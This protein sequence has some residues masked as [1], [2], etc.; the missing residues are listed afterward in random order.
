MGGLYLLGSL[1]ECDDS[2]LWFLSRIRNIVTNSETR[3]KLVIVTTKGTEK[4]ELIADALSKFP[5]E[6]VTR[7]DYAVPCPSPV[8]SAFEASMLLQEDVRYATNGLKDDVTGLILSCSHDERLC[9]LVIECLKSAPN[10]TKLLCQLLRLSQSGKLNPEV[11]FETIPG[12]IPSE[13]LRW[14]RKLLSWV[15]LSFRPLR[16]FEFLRISDICL[17]I[18]DKGH[19]T[20]HT[21]R[22]DDTQSLSSVLRYFAGMLVV[23]HGEIHFGHP[24][25]RAWF[26][27]Q[28]EP[29]AR[30]EKKLTH[31]E[32]V[33]TC[34]HHLQD[35]SSPTEIWA[36]QFPYAIQFW[37]RHHNKAGSVDGVLE[38]LF[39]SQDIFHRWVSAYTPPLDETSQK[40]LPVAAH[41]G[42]EDIISSLLD[43]AGEDGNADT[44]GQALVEAARA[45]QLPAIRLIIESYPSGLEFDDAYLHEA[46]RAASIYGNREVFRDLV[47]YIPTPPHDIT[48]TRAMDEDDEGEDTPTKHAGDTGDSGS[49]SEGEISADRSAAQL[50]TPD[51]NDPFSW[52]TRVL[53]RACCIGDV[54][55]VAKLLSLGANPNPPKSM[56]FFGRT[57]LHAA[58][59]VGHLR[60][61]ELLISAGAKLDSQTRRFKSSP[62]HSVGGFGSPGVTKL[63]LDH[64]A[65]VNAGDVDG[66]PPLNIACREGN[67]A[68]VKVMLQHRSIREFS[69]PTLPATP[70]VLCAVLGGYKTLE[71]CLRHGFDP[72]VPDQDGD[73]PL[74]QA[75]AKKRPDLVRLML[76]NKADPDLTFENGTPPL[77]EA[78]KSGVM[79]TVTLLIDRGADIEK[80]EVAEDAWKRSPRLFPPAFCCG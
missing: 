36:A 64:G 56:L 73:T 50:S 44:R 22:S 41:F 59:F 51:A 35:G 78:V 13:R 63:L 76:D 74:W 71:A 15:L 11:V 31:R 1:D 75:V 49:D 29:D 79:E 77:I 3:L 60:V 62:L 43:K 16:T 40:P 66:A 7:M 34:L 47:K 10:P 17:H 37:A 25:I 2:A 32:I 45:G 6:V 12:G 48:Q 69:H 26:E 20:I 70:V 67:F 52:L 68:A 61:A 42:L 30:Q 54:D 53:Y 4:D 38:S 80:R 39:E 18:E 28:I 24:S 33:Q 19:D 21:A 58:A 65:P 27:R 8:V 55:A 72:N 57:P 23:V 46:V 9:Q 14:A 5:P